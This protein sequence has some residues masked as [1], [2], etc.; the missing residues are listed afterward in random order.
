[1]IFKL[2]MEIVFDFDFLLSRLNGAER[3]L[4]TIFCSRW[5]RI[6]INDEEPA[7]GTTGN[8]YR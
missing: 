1:M 4:N 8:D 6:R 3:K 2:K 7:Y 5:E